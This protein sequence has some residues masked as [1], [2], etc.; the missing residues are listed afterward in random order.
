MHDTESAEF[1]PIAIL[2]LDPDYRRDPR[3]A[4]FCCLCHRTVDARRSSV[5]RVRVG[6]GGSYILAP[7]DPRDA[8]V[9][10][11]GSECARKVPRAYRLPPD[12]TA[13]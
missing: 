9:F 11:V 10:L 2:D 8:T 4:D 6:L 5:V 13:S 1:A 3:S 7:A 12:T